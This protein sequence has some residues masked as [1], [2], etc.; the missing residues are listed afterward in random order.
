ML[1]VIYLMVKYI[2]ISFFISV[3]VVELM[4]LIRS[5]KGLWPVVY[6]AVILSILFAVYLY[7][8]VSSEVG[9]ELNSMP[10]AINSGIVAAITLIYFMVINGAIFGIKRNVFRHAL[11]IIVALLYSVLWQWILVFVGCSIGLDCL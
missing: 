2:L 9:R 7:F 8:G 11:V 3:V 6:F 4:L 1:T 10:L 5:K